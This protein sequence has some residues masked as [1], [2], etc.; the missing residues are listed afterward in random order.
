[1]EN[2]QKSEHFK[3]IINPKKMR[4]MR[5]MRKNYKISLCAL[6]LVGAVGMMTARAQGSGKPTLAVFVVGMQ[7][8]ALGNDLAQQIA[9]ELNRNS[10]YDVL[11][12]TNNA[13]SNKLAEL[14]T[15]DASSIDRN[16]LAEWG[17]TNGVSMICLVTDAIKGSDHMFYAL[18]IDTKDSKVSGRGSYIRTGVVST[19]LP[20]VSLALSRQLDGPGRRRSAPAPT[21]SYPAELDIEMVYVEGGTFTMGCVPGR[22]VD[23]DGTCPSNELPAHPVTLSNFYVG[24]FLI[25]WAQWIPVMGGSPSGDDQKPATVSRKDAILFAEKLSLITGKNY[26]LITEAEWEYAARGGTKSQGYRYSGSNDPNEVGCN[27]IQPVGMKKPNELG[28]YDMVG[29]VWDYCLDHYALY[30]STPV[31]NP[32]GPESSIYGRLRR[33][34]DYTAFMRN[35][36]RNSNPPSDNDNWYNSGFRVVLPAQ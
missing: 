5:K 21:R 34:G 20:R 4:K 33:G 30:T 6:L 26:R 16:A 2:V 19:D 24:K 1:V 23:M 17:R 32:T 10:R 25:T 14:R 22:D 13:V 36:A 18:L 11:P 8:D 27:T 12:S 9:A 28:I 3:L 29:N 31:T 15:Q 35:S 7:T